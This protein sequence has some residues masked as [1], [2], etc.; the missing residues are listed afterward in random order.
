[1]VYEDSLVLCTDDA[2]VVPS[3]AIWD[4]M[5]LHHLYTQTPAAFGVVG[6]FHVIDKRAHSSKRVSW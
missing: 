6:L 1:M 4:Y 3:D 2:D 5:A